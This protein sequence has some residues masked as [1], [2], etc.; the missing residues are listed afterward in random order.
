MSDKDCKLCGSTW[1]KVEQHF[2]PHTID[3]MA[4]DS[5]AQTDSRGYPLPHFTPFFTPHTS[6]INISAQSFM[7]HEN[8]Y[9][10]PPFVVIG[11]V[12]NYL[13]KCGASFTIIVPRIF[14]VPFWW[15]T[16][17]SNS[18]T[19]RVLGRKGDH[20]VLLFPSSVGYFRS[21]PLQWDL[22]AFR[23]DASSTGNPFVSLP[24]YN[25]TLRYNIDEKN[26]NNS[27]NKNTT[28]TTL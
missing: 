28:I 27:N 25:K 15:P 21:R 4:L 9:V 17:E 20:D 2:G 23:F 3:L 22:L 5:N 10:F 11:P 8:A 18:R 14:P 7:P 26:D 6:G 16:L 12:L 19:S 13:L 1:H 24:F